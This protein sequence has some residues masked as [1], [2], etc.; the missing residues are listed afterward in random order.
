MTCVLTLIIKLYVQQECYNLLNALKGLS[1]FTV[2]VIFFRSV[3]F[4]QSAS[5]GNDRLHVVSCQQ[6]FSEIRMHYGLCDFIR[7]KWLI[8]I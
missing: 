7:S 6:L 3:N 5:D 1:I 2:S 8:Y 4:F